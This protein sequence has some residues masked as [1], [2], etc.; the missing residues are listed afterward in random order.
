MPLDV[1]LLFYAVI[2]IV[3][4]VANPFAYAAEFLYRNFNDI[5][6]TLIG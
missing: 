6:G 2:V 4:G 3:G 1:K 5:Y